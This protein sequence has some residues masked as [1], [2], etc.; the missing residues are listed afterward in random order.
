MLGA[1]QER[2]S[3]IKLSESDKVIQRIVYLI[4]AAI[5]IYPGFWLLRDIGPDFVKKSSVTDWLLVLLTAGYVSVA[6]RQ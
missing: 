5:M 1:N 4:A 3:R 6:I 2:K